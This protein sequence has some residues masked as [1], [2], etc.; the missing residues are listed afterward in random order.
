VWSAVRSLWP[1]AS[2]GAI[3]DDQ[4]L[5]RPDGLRINWCSG[6]HSSTTAAPATLDSGVNTRSKRYL[7]TNPTFGQPERLERAAGS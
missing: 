4:F 5:K 1:P 3:G 2:F 6:I 7:G